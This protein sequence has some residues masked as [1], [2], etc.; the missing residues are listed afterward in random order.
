MLCTTRRSGTAKGECTFLN[1]S[2]T[3]SCT[4]NL[5][6]CHGIG[7]LIRFQKMTEMCRMSD[8]AAPFLVAMD[9]D[10][11]AFWCFEVNPSRLYRPCSSKGSRQGFSEV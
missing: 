1:L 9:D 10:A 7:Q 6:D 3:L 2:L 11:L 5:T 8:L 4:M